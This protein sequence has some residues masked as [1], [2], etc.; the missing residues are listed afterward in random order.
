LLKFNDL[1]N[2]FSFNLFIGML[3]ASI[4][5]IISIKFLLKYIR[6]HDFSV[7]AYYRLIFAIIIIVKVLITK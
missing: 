5:G 6:K 2:E 1:V 3:V 7:F 4:F